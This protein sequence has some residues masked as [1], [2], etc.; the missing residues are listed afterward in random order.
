MDAKSPKTIMFETPVDTN[1][2]RIKPLECKKVLSY[3]ITEDATACRLRLE[4]LGCNDTRK[5]GKV[6]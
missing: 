2:L 4:I 6:L 3:G 1:V 5:E